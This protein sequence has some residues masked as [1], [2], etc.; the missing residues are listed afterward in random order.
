[1]HTIKEI[2]GF[3]DVTFAMLWSYTT[4]DVAQMLLIGS[5][6]SSFTTIDNLIKLLLSLAGLFYFILRTHHFFHK[7]K[8]ERAKLKE[9]IE[10]LEKENNK[11]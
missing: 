5:L 10:L 4:I 8:L 11:N 7:W 6:P 1:M 3:L 9:E 2:F